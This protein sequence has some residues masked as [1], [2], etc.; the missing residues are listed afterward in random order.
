MIPV[1]VH[2]VKT[3]INEQIAAVH[4]AERRDCFT[5]QTPA[6]CTVYIRIEEQ[7]NSQ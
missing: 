2:A 7:K 3:I 1:P 4:N 6:T 5:N